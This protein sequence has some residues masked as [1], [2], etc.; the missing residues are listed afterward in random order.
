MILIHR[1]ILWEVIKSSAAAVALFTFILI[2]GNA[3]RE[4]LAFLLDGRMDILLFMHLIA[5][6]TPYVI[7][8]ALPMGV[9]MGVLM[10][11]GKMCSQGEYTAYRACGVSLGFLARP[12]WLFA[13]LC[14]AF[15]MI[16][17]FYYAPQ[18]RAGYFSTLSSAVREDPLKFILPQT[19]VREFPGYILYARERHG[20]TLKDFWIW[21]L[22]EHNR[23]LKLV[24]SREG[25]LTFDTVNDSLVL[26]LKKGFSELRDPKNPDDLKT[27]RPT[28]SFDR[29]NV[30]L[31]LN[32]LV[33]K[34]QRGGLTVLTI[35][36]L[37]ALKHKLE[38]E[39]KTDA[40]LSSLTG[41]PKPPSSAT[42]AK[43]SQINFQI[44]QNLAFA[45]AVLV[46]CMVGVPL[47]IKAQRREASA[48]LAIAL[49]LALG[50]YFLLVVTS[51]ASRTPAIH[52]EILVWLPNALFFG[53]GVWLM[54]RV[55]RV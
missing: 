27:I 7:A 49:G 19:F 33:S 53:L 35:D 22:D 31:P 9:L 13:L 4:I 25:T 38:G 52:P 11:L 16:I 42:L 21:E 54:S 8:Y 46:L 30:R 55:D 36:K 18:A 12:I 37:L 6:L 41:K 3:I 23:P 1:H 2:T 45:C 44:Q 34:D 10:V 51:W 26:D 50:Y 28:L 24:R 43:L 14:A 15:L 17:N 5:L 40:S 20:N 32:R 29:A 48:N 47:G 39:L